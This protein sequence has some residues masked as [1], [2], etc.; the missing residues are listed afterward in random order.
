MNFNT[1][2][3]DLVK[4]NS[5]KTIQLLNWVEIVKQSNF[6]CKLAYARMTLNMHKM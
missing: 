5:S 1:Y 3:K 6:P 2:T 4:Q